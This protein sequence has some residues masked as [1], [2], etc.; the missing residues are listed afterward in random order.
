MKLSARKN[1]LDSLFKEVWIFKVLLKKTHGPRKCAT[2][3]KPNAKVHYRSRGR[4]VLDCTVRIQTKV[5]PNNSKSFGRQILECTAP[6][7]ASCT[8][9]LAREIAVAS[10]GVLFYSGRFLRGGSSHE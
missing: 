7:S 8:P 3:Q 9:E 10:G 2:P 5:H 1:G 4:S 6:N